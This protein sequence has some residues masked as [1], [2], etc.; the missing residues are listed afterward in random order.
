MDHHVAY[1]LG[2]A[3][4]QL[5]DVRASV[6][7]LQQAAD[8]GFPCYPWLLHDTLLDPVRRALV[9]RVLSL[10][11]KQRPIDRDRLRYYRVL[12][13]ARR[14]QGA[15]DD[16]PAEPG[17]EPTGFTSPAYIDALTRLTERAIA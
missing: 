2:A 15:L 9:S 7:W 12:A 5:G 6:R 17:G 11:R 4:A 3:W 16:R 10:Y 13:A 14:L 8:T 1:S